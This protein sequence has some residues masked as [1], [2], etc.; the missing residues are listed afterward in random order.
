MKEY[1][2]GND[3][4]GVAYK[5]TAKVLSDF[6]S[7]VK[8]VK[9]TEQDITLGALG[10]DAVLAYLKVVYR[11]LK[12]DGKIE[13]HE[14]LNIANLLAQLEISDS[15]EKEYRDYRFDNDNPEDIATAVDNLKA[16]VPE[17]SR[18]TIFQ[19]LINDLLGMKN[20]E[21]LENWENDTDLSQLMNLLPVT[22]EQ[23]EFFVRNQQ[24]NNR[25]IKERLEDGQVKELVKQL[26]GIGTGA[27][28]SLAALAATGAAVGAFGTYGLGTLAIATMSTG[29][30]ALAAV[31]IG[32]ASIVGYEGFQYLMSA[33]GK[34]K[35][36]IRNELLQNHVVRLT[37]A[38]QFL[39]ADIN[40]F[41][42]EMNALLADKDDIATQ[43]DKIKAKLIQ[44]SET[45]K[46]GKLAKIGATDLAREQILSEL[47]A[48]LNE[49]KLNDLLKTRAS[50]EK[51]ANFIKTAYPENKL[52]KDLLLRDL[53]Q[54]Q[55]VL[56]KIEYG[57][58]ATVA[59]AKEKFGSF[60]NKVME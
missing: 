13:H 54:L 6:N 23:A 46:A 18:Q 55:V 28:A 24:L 14:M 50:G 11:Y 52:N 51:I 45:T 57:K 53:K 27:G 40:E 5:L 60:L 17:G 49:D 21:G 16:L 44:I 9:S 36:A 38:Q 56:T 7:V 4:T 48:E 19:S 1:T 15:L 22:K 42:E 8:D 2:S 10:E 47:P 35:Y 29:G 31:G 33:N 12:A 39:M 59:N 32:A 41:T 25:Q 3:S 43:Y 58:V 37:R 20:D 26:V 30:L 34:E